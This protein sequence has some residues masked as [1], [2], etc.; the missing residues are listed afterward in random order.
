MAKCNFISTQAKREAIVRRLKTELEAV[1]VTLVRE[2][3]E[4]S[5]IRLVARKGPFFA[6]F[7]LDGKSRNDVV[8]LHWNIDTKSDCKFSHRFE[9]VICG[10]VNQFH[11]AKATSSAGCIETL[12]HELKVGF[13]EVSAVSDATAAE[14]LGKL[15]ELRNDAQR[16]LD[17]PHIT[18]YRGWFD[19]IVGKAN[20]AIAKAEGRAD[21]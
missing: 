21:A 7:Y 16:M 12:V 11:R 3:E 1:G 13:A 5:C 17:D 2:R 19:T 4:P 10:T 8:L 20:A 9:T 15:Y 18:H 14:L 6:A